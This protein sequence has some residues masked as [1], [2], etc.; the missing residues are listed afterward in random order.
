M[1]IFSALSPDFDDIAVYTTTLV[2]TYQ[3]KQIHQTQF[4]ML[5][6]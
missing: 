6:L 1:Y 5:L 3:T 2:N 4:A